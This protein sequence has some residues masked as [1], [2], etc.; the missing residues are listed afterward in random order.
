MNDDLK[1]ESKILLT[2]L[3]ELTMMAA[4]YDSGMEDR[5]AVFEYIFRRLPHNTGFAI[6]A[7]LGPLLDD[8]AELHFSPDDLEY[9]RS[10]E[11]FADEFIEAI[12]DFRFEC[13]VYTAPDGSLI[14]PNETV[15]WVHGPLAQ[16]Q[17]IETLV[18]NRLNYQ[19]LIATKA[20]RCVAAAQGDPIVEFGLR[21]A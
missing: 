9:L 1:H 14:F 10:L 7:G 8:L 16:S 11:I 15:L 18:L 4:Y 20:A 17:I 6:L 13:D 12:K 3:Y 2:D 21:R 5:Q 19:T